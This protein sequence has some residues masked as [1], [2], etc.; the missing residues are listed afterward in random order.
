VHINTDNNICVLMQ[1]SVP[2]AAAKSGWSLFLC[3][4]FIL[5]GA[6]SVAQAKVLV[7]TSTPDL[8]AIAQAVGGD[9]IQ[10]RALSHHAE[11]PHYVDARPSFLVPLSRA[12][13]LVYHGLELEIGWLPPLLHNARNPKI[14]S[15]EVGHLDASTVLTRLLDV[16]TGKI[17]RSMGDVHSGGNPHFTCDPRAAMEIAKAVYERLIRIEPGNEAEYTSQYQSFVE[18][19]KVFSQKQKER[20]LSLPDSQRQIVTYHRSLSYFA[21]WLGLD[22]V[23]E[24]EPKPGV[25]PSPGHTAKVLRTMRSK[26]I[27]LILQERY[28]PRKTSDTLARLTNAKVVTVSQTDHKGG[29]GYVAHMGEMADE[30]YRAIQH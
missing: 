21:D 24:I 14:Q 16:P 12:D 25:K 17:D 18:Q 6:H 8:A 20:F 4:I 7:V 9:L 19:L 3:L 28:Y 30:V 13:L 26:K 23:V 29:D 1:R 10:T 11:D 5:F 15:G 27:S 2:R 22:V